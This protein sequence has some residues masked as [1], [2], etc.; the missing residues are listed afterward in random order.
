MRTPP[1][2]PGIN[3]H[4]AWTR[5]PQGDA[6]KPERAKRRGFLFH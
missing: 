3:Q 1:H 5:L 6:G 2:A 4:R